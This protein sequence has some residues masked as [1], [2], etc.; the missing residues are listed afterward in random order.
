MSSTSKGAFDLSGKRRALLEA[1]LSEQGIK[2]PVVERIPRRKESGPAPLSFAQQRLWFF[3][4][5]EPGNPAYNVVSTVLLQGKL[6]TLAFE[7]SFS[8]VIRRHEALRTTF[9]V[10]DGEAVQII[11]PPKPLHLQVVDITHYAEAERDAMVQNL[12]HE[13]TQAS[14]DL[15]RGPLL[16][17]TLVRLREDEHVLLLAMHHIVTDGWSVGVF[18]GEVVALYEGYTA[19]REVDLP[20]LP[21]QYADF[22][23]WQRQWLKGDVL[24]EQFA[25]W[26]QQLGG[27]LPILELPTDRRRPALQTYNG[28][29]LSFSLS[30]V[31]SQSLKGLCKQEGVTLFMMLLAVFKVLLYR[32]TGQEDLIVGSPIANRHRRELES[33]IGFFVNTLAMR[34]DL[35]GNPTFK[36]LLT[37]VRDTALGAYTHQDLPFE[38]LVEQLQPDRDLSHSPL[39]QVVFVV[40]NTPDDKLELPGLVVTPLKGQPE[41]AKFDIILYFDEVGSD[42]QGTFEYNTGLFDRDT[43]ERMVQHLQTLLEG[44]VADPSA[45][46]SELPLLTRTERRQLLLEWNDTRAEYQECVCAHQ[47]FEAQVERTPAAVAV[48]FEGERLSYTELNARANKLA[49]YLRGLGV[50]TGEVVGIFMERSLEMI[51]GILGALKTGAACLPLDPSY[52]RERLAFMLGDVGGPIVLSQRRLAVNLPEVSMPVVCLDTDW[53]DIARNSDENPQLSVMPESWIYVIYTSG[54]TGTPKA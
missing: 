28:T 53:E 4:Q 34:T 37:R 14:F 11:A 42:I 22:A 7:R 40:Q 1:L 17:I 5:F 43:I 36:E 26:R 15:K 48:A 54:S 10:R 38:Y 45:R 23:T 9:D 13:Q 51:A 52:P 32:Y 39:V 24:D 18:V 27:T 3:D 21:I 35:S 31:V 25:Y 16:R 30:P 2:S 20:T 8:E 44:I 50:G 19:G 46:I 12:I 49:H 47:L 6:N 41:T 33:L 29:S